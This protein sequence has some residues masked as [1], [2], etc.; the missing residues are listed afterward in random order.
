MSDLRGD[1]LTL[2]SQSSD[3]GGPGNG[4]IYW[5]GPQRKLKIHNGTDWGSVTFAPL[6]TS[7]NPA[8]SAAAILA[9]SPSSPDGV[10]Y[11]DAGG[12]ARETYCDMGRGGWMLVAKIFSDN[13]NWHWGSGYWTNTATFNES[14]CLNLTSGTIGKHWLWN[15]FKASQIRMDQWN[16]RANN[17]VHFNNPQGTQTMY[18]MMVNSGEHT[19]TTITAGNLQNFTLWTTTFQ[20]SSENNGPTPNDVRINTNRNLN[21]GYGCCDTTGQ[22]RI[23]HVKGSMNGCC[24]GHN[25]GGKGVGGRGQSRD[26]HD[27]SCCPYGMQGHQEFGTGYGQTVGLWVK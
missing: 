16:D 5:N 2:D 9:E 24:G 14:N 20:G 13:G 21:T 15:E 6:G 25:T 11:I 19:A 3:V 7:L 26:A 27:W 10:Y 8:P 4:H 17:Y 12:G 1:R 22:V 18:T 23:G